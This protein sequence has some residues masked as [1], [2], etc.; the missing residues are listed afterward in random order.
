MTKRRGSIMSAIFDLLY[1]E[2]CRARLAEMRKQLLLRDE[3][4]ELPEAIGDAG[5]RAAEAS[6]RSEEPQREADRVMG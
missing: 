5:Y 6:S 4:L 3:S 2:Y 1:R